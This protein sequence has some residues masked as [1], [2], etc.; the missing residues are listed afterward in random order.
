MPFSSKAQVETALRGVFENVE[1]E[2]EPAV[3]GAHDHARN[4]GAGV[5][6]HRVRYLDAAGDVAR[7]QLTYAIKVAG[8]GGAETW[9]LEREV[10]DHQQELQELIDWLNDPTRPWVKVITMRHNPTFQSA[11]IKAFVMEAG[12]PV[13]TNYVVG[14]VGGTFRAVETAEFVEL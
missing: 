9:R 1:I 14:P 4:W 8:Q 13:L 7:S 6:Y 5:T 10:A 3:F 12:N 11:S 2:D